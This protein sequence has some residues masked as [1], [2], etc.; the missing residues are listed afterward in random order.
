VVALWLLCQA[1]GVNA[2][3][4]ETNAIELLREEL[5]AL[6]HDYDARIS[7]LEERLADAEAPRPTA[8]PVAQPVA[9]SARGAAAFNPAI[10]VIFQGTAWSY[11][12]DGDGTEI[13]AFPLGGEAGPIPEGLA[14]GET[15]INASANVDNLFT[16]RLTMPLVTEDGET[17]VEVEEAWVESLGLPLGLSTRFGRFYSGIGYLNS[18]HSHTWDFADQPLAYDAFLGGQ[19]AD[20]GV[21]LRWLA[22]TD[23][24]LELGGELLR[25]ANYPAAGAADNGFGSDSLFARVGGDVG[26]SSSWL[27]GLSYLHARSRERPS[28][29][30][31]QTVLF[32]GTTDLLIA[33]F[34]WKWA[35]N[36]NWRQKNLVVQSEL[37]WSNDDGR[38][39]L[40]DGSAP[41]V[42]SDQW[43]WYLQAVYQPFPRWRAGARFDL[44]SSQDPGA[45]FA[46]TVLEPIGDDPTRY[47]VMADWSP[48]EF[49]R[50]RLQY[51]W[52][53]AARDSFAQ[54]GLQYI[55]SIGAHGAHSF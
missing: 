37:L 50:I 52:D 42:D 53:Q 38:Y 10:G 51:E 32:D 19:Y 3:T 24:Y 25:G 22:P 23:L 16:A 41:D 2:A 9:S 46:G 31:D 21:Q 36:G 54:W 17:N 34:V 44:L 30:G 8:A 28:G 18:K 45:A 43:G 39:L 47:T 55:Q 11:H 49:S 20:D 14:L 7:E 1:A 33:E 15:E 35:P 4:D 13:P 5:A 12:G 6:R 48:S 29:E 27:T 40:P 26:A